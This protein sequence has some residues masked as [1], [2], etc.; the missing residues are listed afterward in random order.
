MALAVCVLHQHE[1]TRLNVAHI[2]VARL[3]LPL[4]RGQAT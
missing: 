2:S 3:V 4:L 1:A